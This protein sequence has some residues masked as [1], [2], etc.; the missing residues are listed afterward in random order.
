VDG[1]NYD[2]LNN[3]LLGFAT[4]AANAQTANSVAVTNGAGRGQFLVAAD[5]VKGERGTIEINWS[6]GSAPKAKAPVTV[7]VQHVNAGGQ[8]ILQLNDTNVINAAPAPVYQWYRDGQLLSQTTN[9]LL[10]LNNLG[11]TNSGTYMV[12]ATNSLGVTSNVLER[13]LIQVPVNISSGG[14]HF[15]NGTFQMVLNGTEGDPISVQATTNFTQWTVLMATNLSS[16]QSTYSDTN[17]GSYP[18]RI[19]RVV[20]PSM[21]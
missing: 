21:I 18:R 10:V 16:Y 9:P 5:G 7:P 14:L 17:A 4:N 8:L 11:T 19:Y 15:Q 13:V 6:F 3:G 1:A 20:T 2:A 12:V